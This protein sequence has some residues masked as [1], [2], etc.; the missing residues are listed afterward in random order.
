[1][2]IF[3]ARTAA[4]LGVVL[5]SGESQGFE[6]LGGISTEAIT[7]INQIR[8]LGITTGTSPT[9]FDPNGVVNRWQ[10]A[11]FLARLH[12]IV[13]G[14]LPAGAD[15]GFTDLAG[16]SAEAV[17]AINQ[18]AELGITLGTA[19]GS[20]SPTNPVVREQMAS[21]LARLIRL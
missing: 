5:P 11:L 6:D 3:L 18:L 12:P 17:T 7:A 19:P 8:Q 15:H 9:T 14:I 16:V 1:M 10:M 4:A 13:G 21:F 2:A 20:Y